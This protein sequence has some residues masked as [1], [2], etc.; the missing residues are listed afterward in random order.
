METEQLLQRLNYLFENMES[1]HADK[2]QQ[3]II[4]ALMRNLSTDALND[5]K[6]N[7]LSNGYDYLLSYTASKLLKEQ[8]KS[9][10]G[11]DND[12]VP[13]LLYYYENRH[14]RKVSYARKQLMY[15]YEY[16]TVSE[17]KEIIFAFLHGT[18]TDIQ[19]AMKK[20]LYRWDDRFSGI[21]E[22][23]W[24]GNGDFENYIDYSIP[25]ILKYFP[26]S[27]IIENADRLASP[28]PTTYPAP[29]N[30][31]QRYYS[32]VCIAVGNEPGFLIDWNKMILPHALYVKAMLGIPVNKEETEK[33]IW[34]Y[35]KGVVLGPE[36]N[37]CWSDP[38]F[39]NIHWFNRLIWSMGKL[40]MHEALFRLYDFI[41]KAKT[42]VAA[43][44]YHGL[45]TVLRKEFE[46][47]TETL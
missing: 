42:N 34:E 13:I 47:N 43:F 46:N 33:S 5:I 22:R 39:I 28:D 18:K 38:L 24:N 17:Q 25:L 27:Y 2:D 44:D 8:V 6:Y 15:R 4:S 20:A 30:E 7:W 10:V 41:M 19:W 3:A 36:T 1:G 12:P 16:L 21:I 26:K 29:Y 32:D 45:I 40:G 31:K 23:Y 11:H 35:I 9:Q 37:Y 14:S